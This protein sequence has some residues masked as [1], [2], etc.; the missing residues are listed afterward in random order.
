MEDKKHRPRLRA[1]RH[2]VCAGGSVRRLCGPFFFS[3]GL[4]FALHARHA[5]PGLQH[6]VPD[7]GCSGAPAFLVFHAGREDVFRQPCDRR[8]IR[9]ARCFRRGRA[10]AFVP[11]GRRSARNSGP[12]YGRR[13]LRKILAV[14]DISYLIP[15]AEEAV[16]PRKGAALLRFACFLPVCI[17]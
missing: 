13:R 5:Q 2:P 17:L 3:S 10:R 14:P 9:A 4:R 1:A 6:A 16:Q 7:F 15:A 8:R 12:F 11:P